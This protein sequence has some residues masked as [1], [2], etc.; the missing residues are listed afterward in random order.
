MSNVVNI[1]KRV[2]PD[3]LMTFKEFAQKYGTCTSYLYKLFYAGKIS[4]H[5]RGY[6]KVSESEVL[7]AM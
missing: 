1:N 5:K 4:R 6:W 3:D 7:K 2:A